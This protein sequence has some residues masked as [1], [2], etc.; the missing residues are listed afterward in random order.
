[1]I[2]FS[3]NPSYPSFI[4]GL[5]V[6]S[7]A[8]R[9]LDL[10]SRVQS[11]VHSVD[12]DTQYSTVT[13][14]CK[15]NQ[16]PQNTRASARFLNFDIAPTN[17]VR[18]GNADSRAAPHFRCLIPD[19]FSE[20]KWLGPRL[21]S[22]I[23]GLDRVRQSAAPVYTGLRPRTPSRVKSLE[24]PW[25]CW[26]VCSRV[27]P[28]EARGARGARLSIENGSDFSGIP[29]VPVGWRGQWYG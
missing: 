9:R 10:Q 3:I 5:L 14:T 17:D 22:S 19:P 8:S 13:V 4:C 12:T 11:S 24:P 2:I 26:S 6:S 20:N 25:C 18:N 21:R 29:Y 23:A 7:L 15:Y 16:R 27:P 1:M 28:L